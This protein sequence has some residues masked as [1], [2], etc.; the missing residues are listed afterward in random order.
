MT[1]EKLAKALRLVLAIL[2]VTV[3]FLGGGTRRQESDR[4]RM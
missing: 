3:D 4:T 1:R 2:R